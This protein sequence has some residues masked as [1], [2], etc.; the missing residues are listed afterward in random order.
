VGL[1]PAMVGLD[2]AVVGH[3]HVVA[4]SAE[5]GGEAWRPPQDDAEALDDSIQGT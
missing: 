3:E 5:L 4:V 1:E 2:P